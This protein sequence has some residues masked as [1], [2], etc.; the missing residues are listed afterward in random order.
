MV[1][2]QGPPQATERLRLT[3]RSALLTVAMFGATLALLRL[4]MASQRVLG[5]IFAAAAVAG[6][7]HPLVAG[8]SRRMPRGIAVALVAVATV[9]G[10]GTV[11]YGAIDGL[12]R[13]TRHLQDAAPRR[14]T[15]LERSGRFGELARDVKLRDRVQRF[16]DEAPQRL[17]GGTPAEA[18]RAAAT[19]GVAFLATGV[20]ALFFLLHGPRIAS[21]ASR[22]I[23]DPERR[24]TFDR[25]MVCAYH[26]GF[27]YAR[28]TIAMSMA[29]GV[30][31]YV[32]A[33]AAEVPG[34]A[35]LAL[36][37]ALWDAVPL[38]GAAIGALPIV[39]LAAAVS[40][41]KGV[42]LAGVFIAYQLLE[43]VVVQRQVEKRTLRVG[44]FLTVIAGFAGMEL[45]GL[46]GALLVLLIVTLAVAIADELAPA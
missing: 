15:Q 1:A 46:G 7:L 43:A 31:A 17:R 16:V 11:A 2:R 22:Q 35:P 12:V 32:V 42:I 18:L 14:A 10:I 39:I 38:L 44:P 25:A 8:L 9:V 27:G 28:A 20:L 26:R 6:L 19:R 23:H 21:A 30:F 24:A 41:A 36:W 45:Y 37:A 13:E 33:R 3:T 40:P 5:W 4:V 34:P 29:A